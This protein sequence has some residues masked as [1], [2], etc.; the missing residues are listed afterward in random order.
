MQI[1]ELI[2]KFKNVKL[3]KV[4]IKNAI[5]Y[6]YIDRNG[7]IAEEAK[8]KEDN[9]CTGSCTRRFCS[10]IEILW[11]DQNKCRNT[12]SDENYSSIEPSLTTINIINTSQKETKKSTKFPV[13]KSKNG[14]LKFSNYAV[15]ILVQKFYYE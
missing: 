13:I 6:S 1:K 3:A 8:C 15:F 11:L 12:V 14:Y 9:Y 5:C 7:K 2:F 4:P 10:S